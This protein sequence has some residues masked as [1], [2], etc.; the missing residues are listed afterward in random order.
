MLN[1]WAKPRTVFAAIIYGGFVYGFVSELINAD[2]MIAA[3]STIVGFHF[4]ERG[5]RKA[6]E[7]KKE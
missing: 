1:E 4:G 2:A 5:M 3:F 6:A 7:L